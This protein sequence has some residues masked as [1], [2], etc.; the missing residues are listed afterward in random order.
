MSTSYDNDTRIDLE[1]AYAPVFEEFAGTFSA[2]GLITEARAATGLADLGGDAMHERPRLARARTG[3]DQERS[4]GRR[5]EPVLD[6]PPLLR[7]EPLPV[8]HDRRSMGEERP[9]VEPDE[10]AAR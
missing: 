4:G 5:V 3:D 9:K 10:S 7:I 8:H 6:R 1:R 2:D